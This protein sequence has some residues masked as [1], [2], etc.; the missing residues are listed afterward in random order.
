MYDHINADTAV[1][2]TKVENTFDYN[3]ENLGTTAI[4]FRI[5]QVNSKVVK[6]DEGVAVDLN[7]GESMNVIYKVTFNNGAT[8]KNALL[9]VEV[10]Q[11]MP[12]GFH[13]GISSAIKLG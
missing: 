6:E 9:L 1:V 4:H 12:T 8:N 7:P 10:T 11:D 13:F 5:Y 2:K 3:F